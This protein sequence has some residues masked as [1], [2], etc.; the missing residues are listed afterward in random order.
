MDYNFVNS[1]D[2]GQMLPQAGFCFDYRRPDPIMVRGGGGADVHIYERDGTPTDSFLWSGPGTSRYGV[3]VDVDGGYIA[4]SASSPAVD[5]DQVV[6]LDANWENGFIIFTIDPIAIEVKQDPVTRHLFCLGKNTN[7]VHRYTAAGGLVNTINYGGSGLV[8]G[9]GYDTAEGHVL[10]CNPNF[11]ADPRVWAYRPDGALMVIHNFLGAPEGMRADGIAYSPSDGH[12]FLQG[13]N[14]DNYVYEFAPS[15]SSV[16]DEVTESRLILGPAHPNPFYSSIRISYELP[17]AA[18][19]ALRIFDTQGRLVRTLHQGSM[20]A[21]S[22]RLH[23]DGYDGAGRRAAEGTYF[24][25][26]RAGDGTTAS[27]KIQ[28]LR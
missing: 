9:I 3:S 5:A 14:S 24:I 15:S 27:R 17:H 22:H 7:V 16:H 28:L 25:R 10:L 2:T 12:I 4:L 23:W 26:L 19:I 13:D 20:G 18:N 11:S 21:G 1:W 6:H 8:R